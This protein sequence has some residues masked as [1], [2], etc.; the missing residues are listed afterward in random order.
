MFEFLTRRCWAWPAELRAR[1][2]LGINAR[3]LRL[4]APLNPRAMYSRVDDKAVTKRICHEQGISVP[5]TYAIIG[6]LGDVKRLGEL[7]GDHREFVIKPACGAGGR[8]VLVI[9]SSNGSLFETS[10]GELLELPE[11]RYHISS[12]LSGLY[13]LGG[14]PD[15]AII[16][17]RVRAH[18]VFADLAIQGTPDVRIIVHL[19]VPVA[20][21]VRLPTLESGGRANLHQGAVGVGVDLRTGRTTFAVHHN[22]AVMHH[23]DTGQPIPGREVPFWT[24]CVE[25][26]VR[27]ANAV[28]LGYVGVDIVLDVQRGPMVLE[29]NARPGL[30]IQIASRRGLLCGQDLADRYP[31]PLGQQ[32]DDARGVAATRVSAVG[33]RIVAGESTWTASTIRSG[34]SSR[35][36]GAMSHARRRDRE[37]PAGT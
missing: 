36:S 10:S 35:H 21:M 34:P 23:P 6:R 31:C 1:G 18:P 14:R 29:V 2:V 9:V 24:D 25:T 7:I 12:T 28:G 30:A 22:R 17:M 20:A 11:V 27:L 32:A 3:N 4:I 16:E 8:G 37:N 33:D 19:G 5:E 13:S 26:A 15:R